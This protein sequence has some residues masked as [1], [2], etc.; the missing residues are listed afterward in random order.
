[1]LALPGLIMLLLGLIN[2]K[3]GL[4]ITGSVITLIAI[5]IIIISIYSIVTKSVNYFN[6]HN[7]HYNKYYINDNNNRTYKYTDSLTEEKIAS[8]IKEDKGTS[9]FIKGIDKKLTLIYVKTNKQIESK[10]VSI[11]KI[12]DYNQNTIKNNE[13]PL[14]L[15]FLDDFTGKIFLIAYDN[16]NIELAS[17][18]ISCSAKKGD[19]KVI[20]FN[21]EKSIVLSDIN[22]CVLYE[23]EY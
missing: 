17:S 20:E 19:K 10:G 7:T 13:I 8:E 22:H 16:R 6:K 23:S 9:G 14:K 11:E 5:I 15:F 1:M 2:K 21:F 4:W 3:P 18:I 12:E